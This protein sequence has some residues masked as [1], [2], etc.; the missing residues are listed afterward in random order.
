V[1]IALL[2]LHVIV[3]L[4]F[5]G[6]GAQKLFGSFG[7]QGLEATSGVFHQLGL[8]PGRLHATAAGGAEFFGGI[9]LALG[10]FT[11]FAAAVLIATM[12]A[13]IATVHFKNGIWVTSQG[14]E[15]NLV[16]I[17]ALFVLAATD[18]G[19]YGLDHW[20]G[21]SL[22]GTA[23]GLGALGAGILGGLGAVEF[24]RLAGRDRQAGD[25]ARP[26]AA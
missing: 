23:W 26:S 21:V 19:R 6:H 1:N 14:Y 24:G 16:L 25:P 17:L 3:G 18:A 8:R 20:I 5:V 13:A 10:L 9:L 15:Y 7:G 4:L 11:P 12:V 22:N 2:A